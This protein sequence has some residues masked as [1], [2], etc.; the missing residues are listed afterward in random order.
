MPVGSFPPLK[1]VKDVKEF[2]GSP[3]KLND[4]LASVEG[5]M[6]AYNIPLSQGGY[7]AGNVDDGW[8]YVSA[9]KHA[10]HPQESRANHDYGRRYLILLA[11]R[12]SGPARE[13]WINRMMAGEA[14]PNC[15]V[16]CPDEALAVPEVVEVS[17]RNLIVRQFSNPMDI[18]VALAQLNRLK[19][20]PV[21]ESLSHLKTRSTSLFHRAGI[22]RWIFQRPYLLA[23]F[24][25]EMQRALRLPQ[26]SETLWDE[27][28]SYW[29]TEQSIKSQPSSSLPKRD[30][31]KPAP[32]K[33]V[34]TGSG[35]GKVVTCYTCGEEGHYSPD[36][37]NANNA[38][39]KSFPR[40]AGGDPKKRAKDGGNLICYK[41]GGLGHK[42]PDCPSEK[43]Y[44]AGEKAKKA[45]AASSRASS[46]EVKKSPASQNQI[47]AQPVNNLG[48]PWAPYY[49][50]TAVP[51][52]SVPPSSH[53]SRPPQ[54][55]QPPPVLVPSNLVWDKT[56]KEYVDSPS[57]YYYETRHPS[58][59]NNF[60]T[61]APA[62]SAAAAQ[63]AP[64]D[65]I[66]LMK[67]LAISSTS[68]VLPEDSAK[69][70]AAGSM[71]TVTQ[72][73]DGQN[74]LTVLDSGTHV[75]VAPQSVISAC[76]FRV[77]RQS[78]I[79]LTSTDDM[80]TDPIGVCDDFRFKLGDTMY[81]TKVYVVRKAS[82]QLLLGNE[83]LW[84]V[85]IGLFPRLGAIMVSYPEFQ[86]IKGSCERITAD[87]APPPLTPVSSPS[88]RMPVTSVTPVSNVPVVASSSS[89][90]A[91]A[92]SSKV[93]PLSG[94]PLEPSRQDA[95]FSYLDVRKPLVP[96][97]KVSVNPSV[98]A[99]G[100]RDYLKDA[101]LDCDPDESQASVDRL[102]PT[103]TDTYVR[104]RIDINPLAPT[105]FKDAMVGII[106]KYH[107]VIA[108]T[109]YDL[110]RVTH[111]PHEIH[112]LPDSRGVRQPSR[113]H[114]YSQRYAGVI[115]SK[116]RPFVDMGIWIP[117]PF[118]DWCAQLV[119][120]AKNRVCHDFTDLNRVTVKDAYPITTMTDIF[121]KMSGKG[122]F[123]MWDADRG[124]CQIIMAQDAM[125]KA[126]FEYVKRHYMSRRMLFG[127]TG[128]PAT[129]C[130]NNEPTIRETK[131]RLVAEAPDHDIDN[132][133][134]DNIISGTE[135]SWMGHLKATIAFLE[136]AMSHGWKYKAAKVRIGYFEIKLLGVIVSSKGKRADPEKVETLLSMRRPDNSAEVRSFVGLAHWFQEHCKGMAWNITVLNKL[137]VAGSE[138]L[139]TAA[140]EEEFQWIK[141][142][143]KSLAVLALWSA[144]K[145]SCLYTDSSIKG[146]GCFLTQLDEDGKTEV[147][148]AFGSIALTQTQMKYH[149]T[150]LEALAFIWSLGHFHAYLCAR[151]FL[152]KT[153]HRALKYIFD[154]SRSS[155]PVLARYKLIA[156]EYKFSPVWISGST[157][158]ADVFSRLCIIPAESRS[159]M[160]NREMV[161]ADYNLFDIADI[162]AGRR[163]ARFDTVD[164]LL[165]DTSQIAPDSDVDA[166]DDVPAED[167]ALN[168]DG[169]EIHADEES[170]RGK[171]AIDVPSFSASDLRAIRTCSLIRQ[172]LTDGSI[173]DEGN[174]AFRRSVVKMARSCFLKDG[175]LYRKRRG[176]IREVADTYAARKQALQVAHDGA[177][178]RGV[179]GT[180]IA[181]AARFWF[182]LME[183]FV[184]R[185]IAQCVTCQQF[186]RA[187]PVQWFPN[188]RL[189]SSTSSLIGE[190]ISL[191]LFPLTSLVFSIFVLLSI[192]S[193]GGR[194]FVLA[195]QLPQQTQPISY[196]TTSF[197]VSVSPSL[198]SPTTV[199]ILQTRL[200]SV[201][202]RSSRFVIVFLRRIILSRTGVRN[203]LLGLSNR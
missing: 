164:F 198:F 203:V 79:V 147:V 173:D 117:C 54:S 137:S 50:L 115:E 179:E 81:T 170:L 172:Y 13:W 102:S 34:G 44:E 167:N 47:D 199:L 25:T 139:W 29:I 168:P 125:V 62:S 135:G 63:A 163:R 60:D 85:G 41:C 181:L 82:F 162:E 10:E 38:P 77:H 156:D 201:L 166:E 42:S 93:D 193:R 175:V 61:S 2:D 73:S 191:V 110:G 154:A 120:A 145:T 185:H 45:R 180:F 130:R 97:L 101:E 105:W 75:C 188:F 192:P 150:R 51:K 174:R 39:S 80:F 48:S 43:T 19:W 183:K 49:T 46:P 12:F 65:P 40:D 59:F 7:V 8:E 165:A 122:L 27:A 57:H 15:W 151:P 171:L 103:L 69:E 24:D 178:H 37:P 196:I 83:F 169:Q 55:S 106:L 104:S 74:M 123:S 148:I 129:F 197:V 111:S 36:C 72:T 96:F 99:I 144:V 23:A 78:D 32:R 71:H 58:V 146:M 21:S 92:S 86:V 153:D 140:A 112:L 157:M 113:L 142:Q 189:Q 138:F 89:A 30:I 68:S 177:G 134:D 195:R 70:K 114:L 87:K 14:T 107:K 16:E 182:P 190:L 202:L 128:A 108:W 90:P 88:L 100:E 133:F 161:M 3:E 141:T 91:R 35:S 119:V 52:S 200:S 186:A 18:E 126:A 6:A 187:G 176:I 127:L 17:F 26:S 22:D 28:Q 152:W 66:A 67:A 84:T 155:V 95:R 136:V 121:S 5:N 184:C 4:F 159:A 160:T 132:Y 64:A 76:D 56:T 143:M 116:T 149:I 1:S 109:D 194:K 11:E 53:Q 131:E 9:A 158:I 98:I 118:S 94:L 124:F 33:K 20:D 31:G